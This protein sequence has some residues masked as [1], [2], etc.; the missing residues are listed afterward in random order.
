MTTANA[1]QGTRVTR[2]N[3][4][5]PGDNRMQRLIQ[6]G[7]NTNKHREHLDKTCRTAHLATGRPGTG[8]PFSLTFADRMY[9]LTPL[10]IKNDRVCAVK[11]L[12][13]LDF[14]LAPKQPDVTVVP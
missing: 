8:L 12:S 13:Q 14:V 4:L 2:L 5:R 10:A 6:T 9:L 1:K 7:L 11:C 3:M